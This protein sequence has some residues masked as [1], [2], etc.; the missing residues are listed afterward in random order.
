MMWLATSAKQGDKESR[1]LLLSLID[2]KINT[3]IKPAV[4][5]N[6]EKISFN[7]IKPIRIET[8]EGAYICNAP[9]MNECNVLKAK[10]I[11]TSKS[12]QGN[13]YKIS[14]TVAGHGWQAYENDAW[15]EESMAD[16]K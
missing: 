5:D 16:L 14:G 12:K 13:Y 11:F 4:K 15:I 8:K 9:N 3:E 10:Q 6:S 7:Q 1:K 2:G